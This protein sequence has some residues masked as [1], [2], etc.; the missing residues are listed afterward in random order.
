MYL[1]FVCKLIRDIFGA[2][3]KRHSPQL[4]GPLL[5]E[6]LGSFFFFFEAER[7]SYGYQG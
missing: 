6:Y 5:Q 3:H 1:Y 7:L 4:Q 2:G